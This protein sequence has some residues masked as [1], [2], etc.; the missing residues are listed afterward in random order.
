MHEKVHTASFPD[1]EMDR[2]KGEMEKL[3]EELHIHDEY[4]FLS[5]FSRVALT[6][7]GITRVTS[8]VRIDQPIPN[9]N[10]VDE[11]FCVLP[12]PV[13]TVHLLLNRSDPMCYTVE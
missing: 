5:I 6:G 13:I 11:A 7:R 12:F 10:D 8:I 4:V 1:R 3:M 2:Y 9:V